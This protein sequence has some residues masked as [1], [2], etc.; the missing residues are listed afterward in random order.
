MEQ[1]LELVGPRPFHIPAE[2]ARTAAARM[3]LTVE[4]LMMRLVPIA[5]RHSVCPISGFQV[6]AVGLGV[7]G[8]LYMG[9]NL[10]FPG[11]ALNQTVHGEQFLIAQALGGGEKGFRCLAVSAPPCGHCRQFLN[12][13]DGAS[14]LEI[15][16]TNGR[17]YSLHSLLPHFFGPEDLGVHGALL[18]SPPA[19]IELKEECHDPLVLEAAEAARASYA[20]YSN[21]PAGVALA[22]NGKLYRGSYAE[23]V[24]FNPSLS[25]LQSALTHLVADGV[26]FE[27]IERVVLVQKDLS[28][29]CQEQATRA[30]LL[31]LKP[32]AELTVIRI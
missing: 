15:V 6:G 25:P 5:M 30:L 7:S 18:N 13:L 3:G 21:C 14:R 4:Q 24:A 2:R 20:P 22:A 19:F 16:L 28:G 31:G 29:A 12:E 23:N 1:L 27:A 9:T 11:M 10:E 8:D 26:A 17:Q 32:E